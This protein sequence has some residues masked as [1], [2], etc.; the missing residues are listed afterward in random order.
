MVI[1][2]RKNLKIFFIILGILIILWGAIFLTDY[3]RIANL[4]KPIFVIKH[5]ETNSIPTT[6]IYYGLGYMAEIV[7]YPKAE[8]KI[9]LK[10]D[11][12]MFDKFIVGAISENNIHETNNNEPEELGKIIKV[13][14][15]LY[16]ETGRDNSEMLRCGLMDGNITSHVSSNEIPKNDNESNFEGDY[17]F[18]YGKEGT[19]EVLIDD[20]WMVFETKESKEKPNVTEFELRYYDK[21][22]MW[23]EDERIHKVLDKSETEMYDYSIYVC[24]GSV[25]VLIDG[26]EISLRKAL[27]ENIITMEQILE[28]ADKDLNEGNITGDIYRDG[29][30][31]EYHYENY[32]IIKLNREMTIDMTNRDV[33]I[34]SKDMKVGNFPI[35]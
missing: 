35:Y 3:I 34:G 21:H 23:E 27:V 16:Y 8:S 33:Y 11:L 5:D 6:E 14:G 22:P 9:I 29:G 10:S 4:K 31:K 12:Y 17:G 20:K 30:S 32:T 7:T 19:I 28:K 26:E 13:D 24:D 2:M 25:N 1:R 15:K 18:Q